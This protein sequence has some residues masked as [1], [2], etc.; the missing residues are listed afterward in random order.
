MLLKRLE[1]IH[2]LMK[3]Q[4]HTIYCASWSKKEEF[5][6]FEDIPSNFL[7][8]DVS[9]DVLQ[10]ERSPRPV[11]FVFETAHHV[12]SFLHLCFWLLLLDVHPAHPPTTN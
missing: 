9:E 8:N 1:Q 2:S 5:N 11:C 3:G 7:S 12:D 6:K 10:N 4:F